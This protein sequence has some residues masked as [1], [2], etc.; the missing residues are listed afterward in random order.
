MNQG[1]DGET[2]LLFEQETPVMLRDTDP[3]GVLFFARSFT[4]AHEA[5]EAFMES[6]GLGMARLFRS[7]GF[8]IPVV[9]AEADYCHPLYLGDRAHARLSLEGVGRRS[10]RLLT[11]LRAPGGELSCV[12]R[13]THVAVD[14]ERGKAIPLPEILRKA[15]CDNTTQGQEH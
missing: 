11:E 3:A 9:H 1:S 14:K 10:F 8:L 4:F 2:R 12:V 6:R 15:L 5:Y 13:T 7:E